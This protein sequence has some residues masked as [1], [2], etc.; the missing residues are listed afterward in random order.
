[1]AY[2]PVSQ[3][4][5]EPVIASTGP[6][7]QTGYVPVTKRAAA[8]MPTVPLF[9]YHPEIDLRTG[10]SMKRPEIDL[11]TGGASTSQQS[12]GPGTGG[13]LKAAGQGMGRAYLATGQAVLSLGEIARETATGAPLSRFKEVLSR[14]FKQETKM[15]PLVYEKPLEPASKFGKLTSALTGTYEPV[16]A[17]KEDIDFLGKRVGG[18]LGGIA[19]VALTALDL[20]GGGGL[21]GL[22]GLTQAVAKSQDAAEIS[23][24]L[25]GAGFAEDLVRDAAP[26]FALISDTAEV[27]KGLLSLEKTQNTTRA[28]GYVPTAQRRA[29]GARK[30][31]DDEIEMATK[32]NRTID[33]DPDGPK[34]AAGVKTTDD[35]RSWAIEAQDAYKRALKASKSDDVYITVGGPATGKTEVLA[36]SV[37][38]RGGVLLQGT[39][40]NYART[41]E[42]F[43]LA[44]KAGKKPRILAR[45]LNPDDAWRFAKDREASGGHT[46]DA[47]YFIKRSKQAL[48]TLR[49]LIKEGYPVW[50]KDGRTGKDA[51]YIVGKEQQLAV[52]DEIR[53]DLKHG[54]DN[55]RTPSPS[56]QRTGTLQFAGGAGEERAVQQ[57]IFRSGGQAEGAGGAAAVTPKPQGGTKDIAQLERMLNRVRESMA[58]ARKNPAAHAKAYG[59]DKMPEYQAKE[60]QLLKRIEDAKK[61]TPAVESAEVDSLEDMAQQYMGS[62]YVLTRSTREEERVTT[63]LEQIFAELKGVEEFGKYTEADLEAVK[64]Q[65]QFVT[66]ALADHPGRAFVKYRLP[67]QGWNDVEL[68]EVLARGMERKKR[69]GDKA[70]AATV[71][72]AQLD[73]RLEELGYKDLE[74][75]QQGLMAYVSLRNQAGELLSQMRT[76]AKDIRL[77][78]QKDAFIGREKRRLAQEAA[79]NIEGLRALAQAAERGG[80]KKG[81]AAGLE[82]YKKLVKNLRSRRAKITAIKKKFNLTDTQMR[83]VRGPKDPRFMDDA[84]FDKYLEDAY[85]RAELE[86][87]RD[88]EK[89]FI[90]DTIKNRDLRKTEN[91][92]RALEFPPVKDMSLDQLIEFGAILAKTDQ[93]DTFLGS[94]MIQTAKNTDLGDIRTIGEGRKKIVEQTGMPI[95]EGIEGKKL[96]RWLRDPTLV[97]RDPLHRMFITEWAAKEA[98]ML[99]RRYA[100]ERH[101][102]KLANAAR[103]ARKQRGLART[104]RRKIFDLLTPWDDNIVKWLQ[105][106]ETTYVEKADG[107]MKKVVTVVPELRARVQAGMTTEELEYAQFLEKYFS[108]YYDIVAKEAATR[109]T[110][111]GV[112]HS[113]YRS[114]KIESVYLPHMKRGFFERWRDDGFVKALNM[115]WERNV[116]DTKIDFNA[117]G[118]RGEVL[119]YEK[120]LKNNME[121]MGEGIDKE[122]GKLLYSQNTVKV[123]L[124]YFN[125]F[126]RKLIIDAMTPKI[127]LLEFLMGKRFETPKS[128]SNPLGAEKVHNQLSRHINEW[129]NN[130][131]GQRI[132]MVYAQGDRIES[133]VDASSLLVSI[134]D[135]GGNL[136]TQTASAVG[137]ELMTLRGAK[138]AGWAKGHRRSLTKQGRK[139]GRSYAGVIGEPPWNS[140]ASAANDAGDTLVSGL[141]YVFGDL[142]YRARRQFLLG[143]LTK[144]EFA[145]GVI[146]AKRQAQIKLDIGKWHP[147]P[148]F[149]SV[150]G[151]TSIVKAA[152]KYMEWATPAFQTAIQ[153]LSKLIREMKRYSGDEAKL[154]AFMNSPHF[155]N[156]MR[157]VLVGAGAYVLG[158]LVFQPDKD[159]KSLLGQ[160]RAKAARESGSI[161]QAVTGVGIFANVRMLGMVQD[162]RD[163][164][165]SLATLDRYKTDSGGHSKGDLKG[166]PALGRALVPNMVE[167]LLPKETKKKKGRLDLPKLPK[168]PKTPKPPKP[169]K[170]KI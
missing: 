142:A 2:V 31:F 44:V 101:L 1:M 26:K 118:D 35:H 103:K 100:L 28:A 69:L 138:F 17:R 36:R 46:T 96:D 94:R 145:T 11:R 63:N 128:I 140:I 42:H 136:I 110:L 164:L 165:I 21:K 67:G 56:G 41:V 37:R 53:Y 8:P 57:G 52:L 79:R 135:L 9:T 131:K 104:M 51:P 133:I 65:Y 22:K 114:K 6:T 87:K 107:T 76:I 153:D 148:E 116:A 157:T 130:K 120:W 105:P 139:I 92:Q 49:R 74:D 166:I 141:F 89:L 32:E 156:T 149:R 20:T 91:L 81:L 75:A 84:E 163:A 7:K 62:E 55:P 161:I 61:Q 125:G 58:A 33:I 78:K 29:E 10:E 68:A 169:P 98:D 132:E 112:K 83:K 127:K 99:T 117:F 113:N 151:S 60:A 3:G 16:S 19:T 54:Q 121:R 159:D 47:E 119:G 137:G 64:L 108:H 12:S 109:W 48:D 123:A 14:P 4:K 170:I 97:D 144:E 80:Y 143:S 43:D 154:K 168:L 39:G 38:G 66:D 88:Q 45:V 134:L 147:L 72:A 152:S 158:H 150:A 59:R 18:K 160:M 13:I 82:Q 162:L 24:L 167:Q 106:F 155:Q 70:S 30:Y 111:Q 27:E 93:Y 115:I 102:T 73:R 40:A 122:T 126:E 34:N 71:D 77:A 23:R 90:E 15:R 86:F 85:Q 124:A 25:R 95:G 129:I 5:K 146:S 50:L